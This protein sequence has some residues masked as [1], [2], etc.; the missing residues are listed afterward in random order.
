M[1]DEEYK[2]LMSQI[3]GCL[4]GADM[5]EYFEK[6]I[7][8]YDVQIRTIVKRKEVELAETLLSN[9][10]T[11]FDKRNDFPQYK[12]GADM[13]AV[14]KAVESGMPKEMTAFFNSKLWTYSKL[15]RVAADRWV[16]KDE[17]GYGNW[18]RLI[19]ASVR[20]DFEARKAA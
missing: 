3:K 18:Y 11:D 16:K 10:E 2:E 1:Y 7:A 8:R 4:G 20:K 17:V 5:V 15:L 9:I 19:I 14:A 13:L 6:N 12:N